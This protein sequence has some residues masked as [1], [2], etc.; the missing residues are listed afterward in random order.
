MVLK[1]VKVSFIH[2]RYPTFLTS[3]YFLMPKNF[4]VAVEREKTSLKFVKESP[5][6]DA[7]NHFFLSCSIIFSPTCK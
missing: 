3:G 6:Y 7:N 2:T 4:K 5:I 1:N